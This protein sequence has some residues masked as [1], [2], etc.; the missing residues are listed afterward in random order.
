MAGRSSRTLDHHRCKVIGKCKRF[1]QEEVRDGLK[2]S[3]RYNLKEGIEVAKLFRGR[4][5]LGIGDDSELA[6]L[7]K[8][9]W[10][11]ALNPIRR[12]LGMKVAAYQLKRGEAARDR[13]PNQP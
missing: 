8:P 6:G 5:R 2:A 10:R 7:L 11:T 12:K 1:S 13:E 9:D 4:R 3:N